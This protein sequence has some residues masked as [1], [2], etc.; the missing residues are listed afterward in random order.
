MTLEIAGQDELAKLLEGEQSLAEKL[1][2]ILDQ[3][4]IISITDE[5]GCIT[6]VNKRFCE[7]SGYSVN[8]LLGQ[9]H[10]ILK[11]GY[12]PASFYKEIW[13]TIS[14]GETWQGSICNKRKD[15]NLYWVESTIV[16]VLDDNGKPCQYI[17][18]RTDVTDS[19]LNN[20]R[21]SRS[22]KFANI[23]TWD[24][25]I[26]TGDLY[27]SEQIASLFGYQQ[28]VPDTTYENFLAAVHPDDRQQV[29][30]AVNNCVE[31]G[32][33]YDI[34]HR[35]VWQD[36]SIHWLH[37]SGDVV[38]DLQ[39]EPLHMLGVVRDIT[40]RK[41]AQLAQKQ[42]AQRLTEAQEIAHMGNWNWNAATGKVFW[43][44]EIYRI[45]GYQPGEFEPSYDRFLAT[46]HPED[47]ERFRVSVKTA[48]ANADKL[49]IDH[50]IIL[51][52]GNIRWVHEETEIIVDKNGEPVFLQGVIQDITERRYTEELQKGRNQILEEVILDKPLE[53][54]LE[55]MILHAE[56]MQPAMFGSVLL[57]D[58]SGQHLL[59]ASAPHLPD[60]YNEAINGIQI[61]MGVGSCGT[62]AFSGKATIVDNIRTHPY[63]KDFLNL[64]AQADLAACWSLPIISSTGDVLGTF[65]MYYK[66]PREPDKQTLALATELTKFAAIA[67]EQTRSRQK[68]IAAKEEAERA[69]RA[70]SE[71]LSSMSHEL[72]TPLNAIIGFSQL[73]KMP[74][75]PLNE[76]QTQS[77]DEIHQAGQHLLDLINDILDLAR[78]EAGNL[79]LS[80]E[81]VLLAETMADCLKMTASMAKQRDIDITLSLGNCHLGL[82]ELAQSKL[83]VKADKIRL[84]QVLI[85]LLTN[86]VKYNNTHG[87][88]S[89]SCN[90]IDDTKL[91]ICV[92]DTG[93][94]IDKSQQSK[95]F[96]PFHRLGA[97]NTDIEGTGIG[98]VITKNIIENMDGQIG[99]DSTP[100]T[101]STFWIEIPLA[102]QAAQKAIDTV[103]YGE[104]ISPGDSITRRKVL[105]IEDNPSNILLVSHLFKHRPHIAL[106]D[107]TDPVSGMDLAFKE[108]PD[109][110]LLDINLPGVNGF[111]VLKELKQHDVTM[112]TPVFAISANAMAQDIKNGEAA[113]FDKYI[114]K[115]IDTVTLLTTIDEILK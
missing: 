82:E 72:R 14:R 84:K 23:G 19:T 47:L 103:N 37:E 10:R 110:I 1:A 100:G 40:K 106:I 48:L 86:A 59:L 27:W 95:L 56:Q 114:T 44:D 15:G 111:E 113:G 73:L 99:F 69:N 78:I 64:A 88:V 55:T 75:E 41:H 28:T 65:A 2:R 79:K 3:H 5:A 85:N 80:I 35:V 7:I 20:D 87:N 74:E 29:I 115:P 32:D 31:K 22:Q 67:I 60:F 4:S 93:P 52:D 96:K 83:Q 104:D 11:S 109:L 70:K 61:G 42:T 26:L 68:L 71:F 6:F 90:L 112:N 108:N 8:E 58:D 105:Y 16:P 97:E 62:T 91:R 38:R 107:A 25:N 18:A 51:P 13:A 30:D 66:E 102:E 98:L 89:I 81:N 76:Q 43:S 12:H 101:G 34:E 54:I 49:S 45:F 63:W 46:I 39:G 24:W 36:G 17:S 9:N 94:G 53:S 21:F 92:T 57:L 33:D 77:I 50:R